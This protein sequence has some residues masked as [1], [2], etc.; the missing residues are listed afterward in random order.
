MLTVKKNTNSLIPAESETP[1]MEYSNVSFN[2][3]S[4]NMMHIE[5]GEP[6]LCKLKEFIQ[7]APHR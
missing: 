3:P 5:P 4:G 2:K 7:L 1:E 6:Q